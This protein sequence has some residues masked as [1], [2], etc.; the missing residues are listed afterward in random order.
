MQNLIRETYRKKCEHLGG[1]KTELEGT[2]DSV[3]YEKVT[4]LSHAAVEKTHA[5]SKQSHVTKLEA[6]MEEA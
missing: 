6:L 5:Q 3:D 2:M 1:I 4:R